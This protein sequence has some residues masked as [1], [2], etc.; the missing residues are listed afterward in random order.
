MVYLISIY[1]VLLSVGACDA[2]EDTSILYDKNYG[3]AISITFIDIKKENEGKK[4]LRIPE[5]SSENEKLAKRIND[6]LKRITGV[7]SCLTTDGDEELSSS[8]TYQGIKIVSFKYEA[9][10]ECGSMPG[11][12]SYAGG[13]NFDAVSDKRI[14]LPEEV[15]SENALLELSDEV[16]GQA[17]AEIARKSKNLQSICPE[18]VFSVEFYL[19]EDKVVF[20]NFSPNT[21]ILLVKSKSSFLDNG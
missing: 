19:L 8:L 1:F 16:V 15:L 21:L 3:N 20:W 14:T 2:G 11:P 6:E 4:S 9:M 18:P 5:I 10:A 12:F 17:I 13:I 7:Y